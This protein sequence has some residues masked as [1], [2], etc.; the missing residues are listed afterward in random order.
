MTEGLATWEEGRRNEAWWRN[1]RRELVDARANG[2]LIPVRRLNGA[3]RGPRVLF[4]YYQSGLLSKLLIEEHGFPSMVRLLESFDAGADLDGAL[5][6]VFDTT[7]EELDEA[8]LAYVDG[9]VGELHIEPRWSRQHTFKRRFELARQAPD[10]GAARVAWQDAWAQVGWGD[11]GAGRRVDAEGV[12]RLIESAGPLPPRALFLKGEIALARND[13]ASAKEHFEAALAAG[14]EDFRARMALGAIAMGEGEDEAAL[15]HLEA[16]EAAFPGFDDPG[17]SAELRIA[18][19]LE[20]RGDREGAMAARRRWL[21]WNAGED[22]VRLM[23]ARWLAE[24]GRDE[25]ALQLFEEANEV[26]PFRRSLHLDWA[27]SLFALGRYEETLREAEVGLRT[28]RQL[29]REA[30]AGVPLEPSPF[31]LP[32]G[33]DPDAGPGPDWEAMEIPLLELKAQALRELGRL[34]EAR[35]SAEEL[36]AQEADNAIAREVLEG[37]Q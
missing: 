33:H 15:R 3:F 34:E 27:R 2:A 10:V 28:P 19:H 30:A 6:D 16:A 20:R 29:E 5:R 37:A 8:F 24:V 25:D 4:A 17:L 9:I 14:G 12:L 32:E 36:Q 18:D 35:A 7:P 22:T 31:G 11:L 1:Y 26:D 21:A 23:V 13:E